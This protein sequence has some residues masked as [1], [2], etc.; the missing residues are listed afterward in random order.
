MSLGRAAPKRLG[1]LS[2]C[3][4]PPSRQDLTGTW[5]GSPD[6][7]HW[8]GSTAM[9]GPVATGTHALRGTV[10]V[11]RA[12]KGRTVVFHLR[13]LKGDLRA[14][15]INGNYVGAPVDEPGSVDWNITPWVLPGRKNDLVL[16][17]SGGAETIKTMALNFYEPGTY[18]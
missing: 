10:V 4:D 14:L 18:P 16:I 2:Y 17:T 3:P 1:I 13:A 15:V 8:L 12:A 6:F 9:P 11:A 7:M 5:Q